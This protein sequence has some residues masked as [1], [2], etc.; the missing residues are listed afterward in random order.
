MQAGVPALPERTV[1]GKRQQC[2]QVFQNALADHDRFVAG[3]NANVHVQTERD[4]PHAPFLQQLDEVEV[5]IVLRDLLILPPRKWVSAAPEEP[6]SLAAGDFAYDP[7]F[8][9]EIA[10]GICDGLTNR[11]V[12]FNVTLEKLGLDRFFQAGGQL[13]DYLIHPTSDRH[14]IAVD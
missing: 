7:D 11:R 3:I 4:D 13:V 10:M 14:R 2:R 9:G 8:F 12:D 5:A 1:G 6:H